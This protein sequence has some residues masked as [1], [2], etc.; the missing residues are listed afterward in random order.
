MTWLRKQKYISMLEEEKKK[1]DLN[2]DTDYDDESDELTTETYKP[3]LQKKLP[4]Y[5]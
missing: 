2:D 4:G 1:N 3:Q 5:N